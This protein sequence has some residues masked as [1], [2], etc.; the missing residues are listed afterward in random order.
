[1]L[2]GAGNWPTVADNGIRPFAV[3]TSRDA[4]QRHVS[5]LCTTLVRLLG[6]YVQFHKHRSLSV[7]GVAAV[8]DVAGAAGLG[9]GI[10]DLSMIWL[11][12]GVV[13]RC[14]IRKAYL[15]HAL[16]YDALTYSTSLEYTVDRLV[17]AS[18]IV[19]AG[20]AAYAACILL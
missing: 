8:A 9:V 6:Q 7:I 19:N 20:Y 10:Y 16:P 1:M 14:V 3:L 11:T 4:I 12:G 5:I 13:A 17:V 2:I 18:T 15:D